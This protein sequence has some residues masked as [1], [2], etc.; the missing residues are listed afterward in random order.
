MFNQ[1]ICY[2]KLDNSNSIFNVTWWRWEL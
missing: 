2:V 1:M